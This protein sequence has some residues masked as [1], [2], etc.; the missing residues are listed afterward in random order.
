MRKLY[1]VLLILMAFIAEANAQWTALNVPRSNY[2][3]YQSLA[4]SD[5]GKNLF[6]Y[7]SDISGKAYLVSSH[8]Y[9]ATWQT[10][11]QL[12]V[13]YSFPTAPVASVTTFW[14]GDVLYYVSADMAFRKSTD[15]GATTSILSSTARSLSFPVLRL[16]NG[17]WYVGDAGYN[18][19]STDKGV[20]WTQTTGGIYGITYVTANNGNMVALQN[21]TVI[22]YSSDGL[23][24]NKS[25]VPAGIMGGGNTPRLSKA[26][27][28]T[29][30]AY[31]YSTPTSF[32][33]KSTDNGLTFQLVNATIP[34]NT[35]IMYFYGNDIIAADILGTT[36]KSVDGGSTFTKI[37]AT[38][39]LNSISGMITNGTNIYLF[40][41]SGIYR[42]GG[43][44][45][46]GIATS[47]S[48]N[49]LTIFPNPCRDVVTLQ[50]DVAVSSYTI[51]NLQGQ[52]IT[53]NT[54]PLTNQIDVH[55]FSKGIYLFTTIATNGQQSTVR[56]VKQ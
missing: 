50:T 19:L 52:L 29:I 13:G 3:T 48:A 47:Q 55:S 35:N 54:L 37:N 45:A 53:Q 8:D 20:S 36:Y 51:T 7:M 34:T 5:D 12:K 25:T 22:G 40:G 18:W 49:K 2:E 17:N 42:Y 43:G 11:E 44:V 24:W 56:L 23:T 33:L 46:T 1:F 27:D 4:V 31:F 39:L 38:K 15:F 6:S 41:M 9:G 10:Y 26:T 14:D 21:N 16:P 28:G 32:V 30:L